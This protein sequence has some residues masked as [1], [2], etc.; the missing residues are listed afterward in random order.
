[1]FPAPASSVALSFCNVLNIPIIT[2]LITVS[3]HACTEHNSSWPSTEPHISRS[4][5]SCD[6]KLWVDAQYPLLIAFSRD[7][8]TALYLTSNWTSGENRWTQCVDAWVCTCKVCAPHLGMHVTCFVRNVFGIC[9]KGKLAAMAFLHLVVI[10]VYPD[11][12]RVVHSD[13]V[14]SRFSLDTHICKCQIYFH[15]IRDF[16][17]KCLTES[18]NR[19][20]TPKSLTKL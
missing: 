8:K 2:G 1:M 5:C 14:L 4:L 18:I 11:P 15:V 3:L 17:W 10:V 16:L 6:P 9:S 19:A 12:W 7:K 20:L 13:S